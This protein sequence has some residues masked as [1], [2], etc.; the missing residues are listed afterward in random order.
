MGIIS[1]SLRDVQLFGPIFLLNRKLGSDCGMLYL[2]VI[3]QI[4]YGL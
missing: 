4:E 2:L 3:G 1:A